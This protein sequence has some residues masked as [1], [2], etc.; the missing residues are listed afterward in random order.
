MKTG[1]ISFR[2]CHAVNGPFTSELNVCTDTIF[3]RHCVHMRTFVC[4]FVYASLCSLV[5]LHVTLDVMCVQS[6]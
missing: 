5:L 4:A 6:I 3:L 2:E 1:M